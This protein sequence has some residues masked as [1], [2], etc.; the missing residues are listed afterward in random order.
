[1]VLTKTLLVLTTCGL[2]VPLS[3]HAE[4]GGD[5]E[6]AEIKVT[7]SR[8]ANTRPAG[9][10]SSIATQLRFDPLTEMQSRGLPEGQAD[11]AV[12]GGLF[13]NTGFK[14]GAVTIMDPQTGHY[15][16]GV[17]IAPEFLQGPELLTGIDNSLAGFN[18]NIATVAYAFRK[19]DDGGSVLAGAGSDRWQRLGCGAVSLALGRRWHCAKWRS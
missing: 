12:R 13:E 14:A 17:P 9:T 4:D 11:V 18:S 2:L 1:M 16:A 3:G 10:Y 6:L 19:I 8:V 5:Q 7:A 15:A